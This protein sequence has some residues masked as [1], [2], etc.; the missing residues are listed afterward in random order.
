MKLLSILKETIKQK[1]EYGCAMLFFD[2]PQIDKIHSM[3]DPDDIY[4]ETGDRTFGLE[5]DP[6]T[7]LLFGLHNNVSTEDVESVLDNFT[8]DN[9]VI[10]NV[11][12]F[13]NPQ[14]D[15]LK[16][17]VRGKNLHETN[18]ELKEFPHT[19]KFPDYHPHLTIGYLKPGRGRKYINMFKGLKFVLKPE[20]AVYSKPSGEMDVIDINVK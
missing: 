12:L 4:Y 8:Y 9:C 5:N 16:F 19:N 13:E 14:F 2:F 20:Y 10:E 18:E 6:H 1:F 17:D 15:V 7:T 3:I 11:S